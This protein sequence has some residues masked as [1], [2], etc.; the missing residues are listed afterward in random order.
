MEQ[1]NDDSLGVRLADARRCLERL[2][3]PAERARRAAVVSEGVRSLIAY[4]AYLDTVERERDTP[5]CAGPRAQV[6]D[7]AFA[8]ECAFR[9]LLAEGLNSLNDLRDSGM[10][11]AGL[12]EFARTVGGGNSDIAAMIRETREEF[13]KEP[14]ALPDEF[15]DQALKTVERRQLRVSYEAESRMLVVRGLSLVDG[16]PEET[17][18][19]LAPRAGD[20]GRASLDQFFGAGDRVGIYAGPPPL[21][22]SDCHQRASTAG[23]ERPQ[24]AEIYA[25][26][27]GG[28]AAA[29]EA[30]YRHARK[31][32][33]Y[34][35][36]T[37]LRGHDPGVTTLVIA[38]VELAVVVIGLIVQAVSTDP[39]VK[40]IATWIALIA[41]VAFL[42][43][44]II[45]MVFF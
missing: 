27:I 12:A 11:H 4:R 3:P 10:L 39:T 14:L 32:S 45:F 33:Q 17:H 5:G 42:V 43:T 13:R 23:V 19:R 24:S 38:G 34:G 26:S 29:R 20:S 44:F 15:F 31:V 18:V 6:A 36:G 40:T 1:L 37:T 30:L 41:W 2:C 9:V 7:R 22:P 28:L 25:A 21:A 16:E 35:H 8:E